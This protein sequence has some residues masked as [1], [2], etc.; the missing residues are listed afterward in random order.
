MAAAAKEVAEVSRKEWWMKEM[1][2]N[3]GR[4]EEKGWRAG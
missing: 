3:R 2:K 4:G 1:E